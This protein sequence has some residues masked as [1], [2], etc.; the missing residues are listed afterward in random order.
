V[1]PDVT[2]A[3]VSLVLAA[4]PALVYLRN[5]WSYRPPPMPDTGEL[6]S[7][8]VLI[9]ARNESRSIAVSV[10]A[11]LASRCVELEVIVLDDHSEDDTA[12]IV[13]RIGTADRRVR[14]ESAPRLPAGW[15]GKQHACH[16]LAKL[17]RHPNLAFIDADVRLAPDALA[18]MVAFR[19]ARRADLVSGFPRQE[20]G[21]VLE[22]LVIPLIHFL[23][24]GFLP[25]HRMRWSRR[26]G[27]GVG[28]GQL[29]VTTRAAYD[30]MGGHAAV[31][32][33]LHDGITLP[34]AYRRAG[35]AT[36][37]CDATGL[38]VCRM[39]RAAGELWRGLAKNAREG[40]A[41]PRLLVPSTLLLLGGQVLPFAL[42]AAGM[43]LSADVLWLAGLAVV[44][45]Y[46]PRIH[47]AFR[48]RESRVGALLHPFGVLILLAI[49]W[50]AAGRALLGR[51]AGWKGRVYPVTSPRPAIHRPRPCGVR[52]A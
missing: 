11:A 5:R 34:R 4:W 21:T 2:I 31:R 44:G 23:F 41:S 39:Y 22:K 46:F 13:R 20:T 1:T 50:Y 6:P 43:W 32:G 9:P 29:F 8:S 30:A 17:A 27:Y 51:P 40:L 36:D 14:L 37:V 47:A 26:P 7:V 12:N 45:A 52:P 48:F 15:C 10:G 33:S 18:R 38:A 3:G 19:K 35:L 25:M 42:L 16:T 28:C 24:L 49:Q